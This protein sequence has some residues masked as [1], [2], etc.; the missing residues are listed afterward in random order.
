MATMAGVVQ[1]II[2]VSKEMVTAMNT[3]NVLA[4]WSVVKTIVVDQS[5]MKRM[6]AVHKTP[7][8]LRMAWQLW[9]S[10]KKFFSILVIEEGVLLRL[11]TKTNSALL[12]GI[13]TFG[14]TILRKGRNIRNK[15][16]TITTHS[17]VYLSIVSI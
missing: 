14:A 13:Q 6:I 17:E 12:I 16:R 9:R 7:E 10:L 3:T 11:V 4:P 15:A 1:S 2:R 5:L 8:K